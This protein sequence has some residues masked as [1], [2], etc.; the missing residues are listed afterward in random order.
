MEDAP[1]LVGEF[2][3]DPVCHEGL[4][5]EVPD[6]PMRVGAVCASFAQTRYVTSL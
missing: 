2:I 4:L 5:V 3:V 6:L 1:I